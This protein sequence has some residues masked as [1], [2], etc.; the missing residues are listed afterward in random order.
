MEALVAC[1]L[2]VGVELRALAGETTALEA[3][4]PFHDGL[5][6]GAAPVGEDALGGCVAIRARK[7]TRPNHG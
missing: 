4:Q 1:H 7:A 5:L 6:D 2:E 3:L